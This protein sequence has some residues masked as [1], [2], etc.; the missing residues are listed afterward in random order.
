MIEPRILTV[1][2]GQGKTVRIA[3]QMAAH[4]A[5]NPGAKIVIANDR[6]SDAELLK[7][8]LKESAKYEDM[9][10]STD[11]PTKHRGKHRGQHGGAFGRVRA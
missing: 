2:A 10:A 11:V 7:A 4:I 1:G 6:L 5:A 8:A 9:K 3:A